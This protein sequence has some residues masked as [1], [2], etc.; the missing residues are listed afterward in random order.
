MTLLSFGKNNFV[1]PAPTYEQSLF[2]LEC[3]HRPLQRAI[4]RD[5]GGSILRLHLNAQTGIVEAEGASAAENIDASVRARGREFR[6]PSVGAKYSIDKRGEAMP[7][8]T[9]L[10]V[11]NDLVVR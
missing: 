10:D 9:R 2:G 3:Q 7:C 1:E 4:D 5:V 11:R 8:E 6:H